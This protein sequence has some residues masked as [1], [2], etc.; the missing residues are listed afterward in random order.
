M[1]LVLLLALAVLAGAGGPG[2]AQ[3][4]AGT[5]DAGETVDYADWE[6]TAARAE[7]EIGRRS[8]SDARLEELRAQLAQWRAALLTAQNAN[9]ARIATV[10][11]QIDALGAA[12]AEGVTEAPEIAARRSELADLLV[13][14][15]APGIAAV[16]AYR[17]AD[18]LIREIDRIL[19]ERQADQ[20]LQLWPAPV[21]PG[22]WPEAAVGISDTLLRMVDE[23]RER[24]SDREARTEFLNNLPLIGLLVLLGAAL[25]IYARSWIEAFADRL[26]A[27][28]SEA[29]RRVL[30]LVASTGQV[31]VPT[32]GMV[33]LTG[34]LVSS[35][36]LGEVT[37]RIALAL[38]FLGLSLFL[39][40]WLGA[41]AFPRMQGEEA[42]LPLPTE[43]RAEGRFL[44]GMMGL[45]VAAEGCGRS[46]WTPSSIP[47]R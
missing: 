33:A 16:E 41:R 6:A 27:G 12:P 26:Q 11:E 32:L 10:R 25:T 46:R 3:D 30:G 1:A 29:R 43:R 2:L 44:A 13:T 47:R 17:R 28:G 4:A 14:L 8:I 24:W 36:L 34:A 31:V 21:N 20:L 38:P 9:S 23:T 35:S 22:N 40:A 42:V 18:G 15:Q 5:G 7:A 45:V 37:A 39:A 19:R